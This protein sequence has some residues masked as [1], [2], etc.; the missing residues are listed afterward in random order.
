MCGCVCVY[1]GTVYVCPCGRVRRE[2][3]SADAVF[4][5]YLQGGPGGLG[6][7]GFSGEVGRRV[8]VL[9]LYGVKL[10]PPPPLITLLITL[11]AQGNHIRVV[12]LRSDCL[13]FEE[14]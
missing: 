1:V 13:T 12:Y 5:L 3:L 8:S 9:G 2:V 14:Q 6:Y 4:S 7:R 10:L 11:L